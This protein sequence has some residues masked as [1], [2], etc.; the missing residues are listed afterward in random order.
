VVQTIN[1]SLNTALIWDDVEKQRVSDSLLN[2]K[3][4]IEVERT[5]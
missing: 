1:F 4:R 2:F 5:S 3:Q